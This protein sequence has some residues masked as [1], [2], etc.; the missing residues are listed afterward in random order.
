MT[1]DKAD[2]TP[3]F[4]DA[5]RGNFADWIKSTQGGPT[6]D[7]WIGTLGLRVLDVKRVNNILEIDY[8]R[9]YAGLYEPDAAASPTQW[10][11]VASLP[12][13]NANRVT[14]ELSGNDE[15]P[16]NQDGLAEHAQQDVFG[17]WKIVDLVISNTSDVCGDVWGGKF[18]GLPA[19]LPLTSVPLRTTY[20]GWPA[21]NR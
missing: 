19:T 17:S 3:G 18:D 15:P 10:E 9:N 4:V 21:D 2:A 14:V 1:T 11:Q 16:A 5:A 12:D 6:A 20:P 13:A 7:S 8:C